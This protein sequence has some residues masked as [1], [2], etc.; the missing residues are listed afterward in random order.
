MEDLLAQMSVP[1][2]DAQREED[3]VSMAT[4]SR[5][6]LERSVDTNIGPPQRKVGCKNV[7]WKSYTSC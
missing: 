5:M 3:V 1:E 2:A 7:Y 6:N 4:G